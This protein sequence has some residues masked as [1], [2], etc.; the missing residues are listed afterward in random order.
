MT[1]TGLER[2]R[3]GVQ[4]WKNAQREFATAF[5]EERTVGLRALLHEVVATDLPR[6]VGADG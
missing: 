3:A 6:E 1:D 5:G 4:G 2:L